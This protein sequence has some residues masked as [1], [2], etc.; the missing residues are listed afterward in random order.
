VKNSQNKYARPDGASDDTAVIAAV[1]YEQMPGDHSP[2]A[3]HGLLAP[4]DPELEDV[5]EEGLASELAKA[6]PKTW[7][8]RGTLVLGGVALI[9]AGFLG[10]ALVQKNYGTAATAGAGAR[11]GAGAGGFGAGRGTGAG[12]YGGGGFTGGGAQG[13]TTGGTTGGATGAAASAATTGTVKLVD[14]DTIY[15]QTAAGDVVTVKTSGSTTVQTATKGT[16]KDVKAGQSITVQG[17]AGTD[18]TVTATSV[19]AGKK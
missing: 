14:G 8:N 11:A 13:G 7:W 4:I 15:V 5:R 12:A 16:V 3:E 1:P 17:A 6:A 18:G 19:T 2:M 10:G 9:L